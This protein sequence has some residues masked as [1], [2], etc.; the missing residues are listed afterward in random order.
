MCPRRALDRELLLFAVIY[1]S[2]LYRH[3][4]QFN[5]APITFLNRNYNELQWDDKMKNSVL[6][7]AY[8]SQFV[9]FVPTLQ[10]LAILHRN[11]DNF[12]FFFI[13]TGCRR[14]HCCKFLSVCHVLACYLQSQ[15]HS[16]SLPLEPAWCSSNSTAW[17]S[18][19]ALASVVVLLSS[20]A[21]FN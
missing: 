13:N 17:A 8:V 2:I 7:L 20:F 15:I 6:S 21:H 5:D 9:R 4:Q 16:L 14:R 18:T 1:A 11:A 10:L 3:E 12:T 19:K